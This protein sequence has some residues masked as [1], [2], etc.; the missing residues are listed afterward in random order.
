MRRVFVDSNVFL[1]FFEGDDPEQLERADRL[2]GEAA[3]GEVALVTGPPVLFEV[4][5]T[6]RTTYELTKEATLDVL[7]R[8]L[9][10]PGLELTDRA[11]VE[12]SIRRAVVSGQDFADA[13]I[14]ASI[15]PAGCESVATFN[16]RHFDKLGAPVHEF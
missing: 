8:V 15:G 11:L 5:W 3:R 14:A 6:L 7:V 12:E 9:G 16:R 2:F 4:A 13:Y 1:R 10:L